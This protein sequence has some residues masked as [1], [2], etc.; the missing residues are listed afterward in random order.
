MKG[1][2]AIVDTT[3]LAAR[4]T[5]PVEY[6]AALL[7]VRPA[8]LQLRAKGLGSRD[9]LGLLRTLGPMC[10]AAGVPLVANDRPDLAALAGC[11]AV[12][13]GQEDVP[14]ALVKRIAPELAIGISTH[15]TT[16]LEV[17]LA[18]SPRYVGYGPIYATGSKAN[19]APVVG[20]EG[21]ALAAPMA[22]RA[23]IPL[24]A[25][26]G[27]TLE[28]IP[29]VARHVQLC[30]MIADLFPPTSSLRDVTERARFVHAALLAAQ[31][32]TEAP[33]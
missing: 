33:S 29:E 28:R 14:C 26:G 10:R 7:E 30:A 3:L 24:V 8:A 15:T 25:I 31:P 23:R 4:K 6:A 19:T 16:E 20:L 32:S 18:A 2:Y 5:D 13:I 21:L 9:I 17:A 1:L 12:H 22:R 11:E 27:I